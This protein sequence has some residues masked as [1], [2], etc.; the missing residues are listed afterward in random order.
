M[1]TYQEYQCRLRELVEWEKW[2]LIIDEITFS[3]QSAISSVAS[4]TKSLNFI[5]TSILYSA[6]HGLQN[7]HYNFKK[8]VLDKN[9]ENMY[10][11]FTP[12]TEDGT[13]L[14][15]WTK[16]GNGTVLYIPLGELVIL[17]SKTMHAGGF[18]SRALTRNLRLHFYFYLNKVLAEPHSTNVYSDDLGDFS[19]RYGNAVGL[20]SSNNDVCGTEEGG[21]GNT[22]GGM[23]ESGRLTNLFANE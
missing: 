13:F 3:C 18:C 19:E 7:P 10:L 15:V 6:I 23:E 12:K 22:A 9:G 11:G 4:D 8:E 1:G 21:S 14:R 16:E 2:K 20:I 17:P 5:Y